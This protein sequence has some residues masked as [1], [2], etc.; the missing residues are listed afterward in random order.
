MRIRWMAVSTLVAALA[1][2]WAVSI[3]GQAPAAAP[4]A[5]RQAPA[6]PRPAAAAPAAGARTE[7]G[8]PNLN[9]IWQAINTANWD[10]E[11]H[12]AEAGPHNDIMGAWGAQPAGMGIV[13]GGTIPYKPEALKKK[14]D[15]FKNRMLVKITNDPHR[16]DTADP[17]LECFRPGVP[18]ANYMPFPFQIFQNRD[19]ILMVYE[20]KGSMRTIFMDKH[21]DAPVDSWMGWSNGRWEGDTLVVDVTGFNGHQWL[22]RAGNFLSDTAHVVERWTPRGRDHMMYEATIEDP[23]TF[24]RPWKIS[25]PVYRRLEPNAQLLEFNC[26]PFVEEMIYTPLGLY[27]PPNRSSR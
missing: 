21:Q 20:Y 7:D 5:A 3:Q 24:T 16:F 13:E 14:Q 26:V 2:T 25:F 8:R 1:I 15:N 19:Q 12:H 9:G 22:D 17:E 4:A 10:I 18:R 27:N 11:A 23:A 6:A